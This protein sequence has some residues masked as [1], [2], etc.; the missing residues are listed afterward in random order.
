MIILCNNICGK[1][2]STINIYKRCNHQMNVDEKTIKC[3]CLREWCDECNEYT[4]P[5]FNCNAK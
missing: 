2:G 3:P 5:C 1:C 4:T